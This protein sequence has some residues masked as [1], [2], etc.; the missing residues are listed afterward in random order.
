MAMLNYHRVL[1]LVLAGCNHFVSFLHSSYQSTRTMEDHGPYRQPA[2]LLLELRWKLVPSPSWLHF[3][4]DPV[5]IIGTTT[6]SH[7]IFLVEVTEVWRPELRNKSNSS[8]F[9]LLLVPMP[10]ISCH[11]LSF[12]SKTSQCLTVMARKSLAESPRDQEGSPLATFLRKRRRYSSSQE[13]G[14]SVTRIVRPK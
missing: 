13:A 12:S 1:D 10:V 2:C 6:S 11:Y 8:I 14:A 4:E 3:M 7:Q 5:K 9:I